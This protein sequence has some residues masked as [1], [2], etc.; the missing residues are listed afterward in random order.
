MPQLST[1]VIILLAC[2]TKLNAHN[3]NNEGSLESFET[4]KSGFTDYPSE[5]ETKIRLLEHEIAITDKEINITKSF[6]EMIAVI[7]ALRPEMLKTYPTYCLP[8]GKSAGTHSIQLSDKTIEVICEAATAGPGWIII[9]RRINDDVNFD[10]S[11]DEYKDGFGN[12]ENSFFIGL[13]NLYAL[14]SVQQHELFIALESLSNGTRY[15]RYNNFQIGN[16]NVRFK[17]LS[18]GDYDG[19][20]GN[21]LHNSLGIKFLAYDSNKGTEEKT[22]SNGWWID[23][24]LNGI[25]SNLNAISSQ[26][27]TWPVGFKSVKM[28]IRP[29]MQTNRSCEAKEEPKKVQSIATRV[30]GWFGL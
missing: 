1:I 27:N 17:L 18:L 12:L 9:Q 10:R 21:G 28:M 4:S 20:A 19:T 5:I 25:G 2:A 29:I 3:S 7:A 26:W 30:R 24:G 11:M 16:E 23:E 22:T 8:D 6:E 15:A 14:L 13:R